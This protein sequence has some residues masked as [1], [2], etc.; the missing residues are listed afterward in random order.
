MHLDSVHDPAPN[1]CSPWSTTTF[2]GLGNT[3]RIAWRADKTDA[4]KVGL[5]N[6]AEAV[7]LPFLDSAKL[8]RKPC[9]LALSDGGKGGV[10]EWYLRKFCDH[11]KRGRQRAVPNRHRRCERSRESGHVQRPASESACPRG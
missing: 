4:L 1:P 2:L 10:G 7:L 3:G 9:Q 11:L 5:L 8:N 6:D